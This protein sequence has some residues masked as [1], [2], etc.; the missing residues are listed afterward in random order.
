MRDFVA[1]DERGAREEFVPLLGGGV[2]V[3]DGEGECIRLVLKGGYGAGEGGS[4]RGWV[5]DGISWGG[6]TLR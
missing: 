2:G 5:G 6:W 3:R 1:D 4:T